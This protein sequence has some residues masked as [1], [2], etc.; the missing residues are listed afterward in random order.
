[1]G[2]VNGSDAA[3]RARKVFVCRG[4]GLW[5]YDKKPA[6]CLA[7]TCG[8]LDFDMFDSI[9]EA[10]RWARLQLLQQVGEI[11]ELRRQV[12]FALMTVGRAGLA[13]K[14][15]EYVADFVYVETATG[16]QVIGDH[17]PVA[18][19]SPDAALKIRCMAAQGLPVTIF[20]EKGELV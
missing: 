7:K 8:R 11:S 5:H 13:V 6:Q 4:C 19:M 12:P 18:G 20:T 1:M 9:G 16:Q 10:K 15:A 14:W 2:R 3:K 17:K